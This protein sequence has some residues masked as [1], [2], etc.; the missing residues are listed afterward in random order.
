MSDV[1]R[2]REGDT[3]KYN[4]SL[5]ILMRINRLIEYAETSSFSNNLEGLVHWRNA[6]SAL[7][8]EVKPYCNEQEAEHLLKLTVKPLPNPLVVQKLRM[9][10]DEGTIRSQLEAWEDMIR[11]LLGKKGMAMKVGKDPAKSMIE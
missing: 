5:D 8:R 10:V 1:D 9:N 2:F 3:S 11:L 4:T 6:L 7:Q